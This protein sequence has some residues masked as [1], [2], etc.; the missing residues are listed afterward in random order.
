MKSTSELSGSRASF[1]ISAT[2]SGHGRSQALPVKLSASIWSV[3]AVFVWGIALILPAVELTEGPSFSGLSMLLSGWEA[4]RFGVVSWYAN[5]L[6][7]LGVALGCSGRLHAAAVASGLAV[8]AALTSFAAPMTVSASGMPL[9]AFE[10]RAGVFVWMMAI[11]LHFLSLAVRLL[12]AKA[13]GIS[14]FSA[15]SGTSRD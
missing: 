4:A 6:F 5:P 8:V 12:L 11:V 7:V 15:D 1:V 14:S 2:E 10:F 3:L 9:P 13:V